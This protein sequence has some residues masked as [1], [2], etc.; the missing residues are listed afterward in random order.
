[1]KNV[2]QLI[3]FLILLAFLLFIGSCL[4]SALLIFKPRRIPKE[5]QPKT[6]R[7]LKP[8]SEDDCHLCKIEKGSSHNRLVLASPP[9][10]WCEV[11]S[12]RGRKKSICTQGYACNNP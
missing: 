1:M 9:P 12:R 4:H 11:R 8:K 2:H 3:S 6:P 10:P 5:P 7:P